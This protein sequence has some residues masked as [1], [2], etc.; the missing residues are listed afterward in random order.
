M[1]RSME[2]DELRMMME[3]RTAQQLAAAARG[4]RQ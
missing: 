3:G 1:G 2:Q 4:G